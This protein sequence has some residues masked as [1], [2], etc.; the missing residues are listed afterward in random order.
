MSTTTEEHFRFVASAYDELRTTDKEPVDRILSLL[1]RKAVMGADIACGTGRYT[2]LL[3]GALPAGSMTVAV[4]LSAEMLH[5][6]GHDPTQ[7]GALAPL[8][9]S[10]DLLPIRPATLD[11]IA[12]F[13]AIHLIHL[14]ALLAATTEALTDRGRLFIYTR[15]PEMNARSIWGRLFPGFN[16]RETRLHTEERLRQMIAATSALRVVDWSC[17]RFPRLATASTLRARVVGHHYS[18]FSLFPPDELDAALEVFLD[19]LDDDPVDWVDEN[20]LVTCEKT[21]PGA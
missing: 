4:D 10:T 7:P 21:H 12:V 16:E 6:L 20:L 11:W 3:H 2:K 5:I 13:N 17:L 8:R 19:R 15:T 18:T 14:E 1:P 9:A